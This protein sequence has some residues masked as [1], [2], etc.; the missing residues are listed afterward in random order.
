MNKFL[1]NAFIGIL[2]SFSIISCKTETLG[3]ELKLVGSGFDPSELIFKSEIELRTDFNKTPKI[4]ASWGEEA[5][6][7][8]TITGLTSGAIRKYSGVGDSLEV[9]WEGQSSN[10][11]FFRPGERAKLELNIM[12]FD[13]TFVCSDSIYVTKPFNWNRETINGV[14][15]FLIDGFDGVAE[16]PLNLDGPSPDEKDKD[17]EFKLSESVSIQ[18]NNSLYMQGTDV[19]NNGWCG[20]VYHKHLGLLLNKNAD[21]LADLPID[22]GIDPQ[23]LYFN[24]FIYGTGARG[25]TIEF[26]VY[27]IDGGDTL[28]TRADISNWLGAGGLADDLTQYNT[29][30]NDGWIYDIPVVWEGWKLVSVPYSEFRITNDPLLGG[31]GDG[32]KE[33]FKISGFNISILSYPKTGLTTSAYVDYIM[34]TQGGRA[35]YN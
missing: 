8:L 17:V 22:S 3:P 9:E 21:Q 29:S 14:K 11:Y 28:K 12:G 25:T 18:G 32:K 33:S 27:E 19:N 26:K 2:F 6:Y 5:S 35:K 13:S 16:I 20:D 4:E 1:N 34:V 24:A 23:D 31:S 15:Y 30:D 10:I 7:H